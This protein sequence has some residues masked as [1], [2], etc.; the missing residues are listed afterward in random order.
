MKLENDTRTVDRKIKNEEELMKYKKV[1][2]SEAIE[3]K[4]QIDNAVVETIKARLAL[5]S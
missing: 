2:A 4:V 5:L 3:K 1:K